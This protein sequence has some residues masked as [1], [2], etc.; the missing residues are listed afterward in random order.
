MRS[1]E[2]SYSAAV[3]RALA[4][5]EAVAQRSHGMTHSE[6]SRKLEIPKSTLTYLLRALETRGYLRREDGDGKYHLGL[7]VLALA[8]G[9]EVGADIKEI[10]RPVLKR[11]V[12]RSGLTAHLA[13][14]DDSHAVY[15]EKADS[16][17][18]IKMDTWVGK[19]MELHSTAVGKV[20]LAWMPAH[21]V[22]A[23]LKGHSFKRR[24]PKTITTHAGLLQELDRVRVRGYGMDD[25]ENS[26]AARCLAAPVLDQFGRAIAAVGL[27]GTTGQIDKAS[28]RKVAE[29][30]QEAAREI[31]RRFSQPSHRHHHE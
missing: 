11:L 20:L 14:L 22:T 31:A 18:F 26:L 15:V 13:M 30:L 7:K 2:E 5:L 1:A 8:R 28:V 25:E 3:E 4:I 21:E 10:A 16:P 17:G 23:L 27:S 9:V 29:M 24:T 12:E 19:R 6:I